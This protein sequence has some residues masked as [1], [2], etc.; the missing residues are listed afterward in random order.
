MFDSCFSGGMDDFRKVRGLNRPFERRPL[1]FKLHIHRMTRLAERLGRAV[2]IQ[3]CS[4]SETA[5][6]TRHGGALHSAFFGFYRK[7]PKATLKTLL[8]RTKETVKGQSVEWAGDEEILNLPFMD[9]LW[10]HRYKVVK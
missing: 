10:R 7:E 6:E 9:P 1:L 5:A 3:A 8:Q 2:V 4:E